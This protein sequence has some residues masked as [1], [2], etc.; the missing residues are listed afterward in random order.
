MTET[1][2]QTLVKILSLAKWSL[3]YVVL[4]N[5]YSVRLD[6]PQVIQKLVLSQAARENEK[7]TTLKITR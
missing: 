4:S 1:N 5:L 2:A 6:I 3:V 7:D